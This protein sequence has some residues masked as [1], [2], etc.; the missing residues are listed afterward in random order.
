MAP[1]DQEPLSKYLEDQNFSGH[2]VFSGDAEL[3]ELKHQQIMKTF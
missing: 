3:L 2:E 1:S